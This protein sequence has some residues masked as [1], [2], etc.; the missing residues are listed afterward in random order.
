MTPTVE[1]R[2]ADFDEFGDQRL[3]VADPFFYLLDI[4]FGIG[5]HFENPRYRRRQRGQF[6]NLSDPMFRTRRTLGHV[7]FNRRCGLVVWGCRWPV[8]RSWLL[9]HD[10]PREQFQ[11]MLGGN[12]GKAF[13]VENVDKN[14]HLPL[15]DHWNQGTLSRFGCLGKRIQQR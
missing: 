10:H 6:L 1:S 11:V 5:K 13:G 9:V 14:S 7:V 12:P 15:I 8:G 2:I 4:Y 3:V